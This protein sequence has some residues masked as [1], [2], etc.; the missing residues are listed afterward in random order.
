[1][2]LVPVTNIRYE[3]EC[4][5]RKTGVFK[6]LDLPTQNIWLQNHKIPGSRSFLKTFQ[7]ASSR[8]KEL[9]HKVEL[10][11]GACWLNCRSISLFYWKIST[12]LL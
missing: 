12:I 9:P 1:M 10:E 2:L 7:G 8:S 4:S 3:T 5:G 6:L 11:N